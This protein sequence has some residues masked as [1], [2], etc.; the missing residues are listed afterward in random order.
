MKNFRTPFRTNRARFGV[1]KMTKPI[2]S[3]IN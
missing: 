1:S 2:E 3:K